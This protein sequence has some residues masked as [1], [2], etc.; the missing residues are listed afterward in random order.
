MR[1]PFSRNGW[2]HAE[3][4]L[5]F[6][7]AQLAALAAAVLPFFLFP[8]AATAAQSAHPEEASAQYTGFSMGTFIQ[9]SFYAKDQKRRMHCPR[10][11]KKLFL[12][13]KR[14]LPCMPR[15]P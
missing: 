6:C 2:R 3:D 1:E 14:F 12:P 11:L 5:L 7:K 4:E 13:M 15:V 8:A 9:G 10:A